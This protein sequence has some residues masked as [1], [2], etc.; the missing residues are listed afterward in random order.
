MAYRPAYETVYGFDTLDT[1]HNFFPEM[2]YDETLFNSEILAWM[3]H[4][5][6]QLFPAVFA[7]QQNLYRIYSSQNRQQNY[8]TFRQNRAAATTTASARGSSPVP[9]VTPII[10]TSRNAT[11][12]SVNAP[13]PAS[14]P[15]SAPAPAPSP[16]S[17][18]APATV[19]ATIPIT[20]NHRVANVGATAAATAATGTRG[21]RLE[22]YQDP[23][24]DLVNTLLYTTTT[25]QP[26]RS[27]ANLLTTML[28]GLNGGWTT[29]RNTNN[30]WADVPVVPTAAQIEAGSD[31]V[32]LVDVPEEEKCAVCQE[33]GTEGPWR[34]LHCDH[35]FHRDCVDRWFSRNVHCPVCRADIR[36]EEVD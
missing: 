22:T 30:V 21:F 17:A 28:M 8:A 3:R 27:D 6:Q 29:A 4:R 36:G 10:T 23:M 7:R 20:T 11:Q 9:R 24:E 5:I 15:A 19:I 12:P 33:R 25:T 13:A 26:R 18:L 16:A 31:V 34:H 2:I 14:A 32:E 35:Y 1:L